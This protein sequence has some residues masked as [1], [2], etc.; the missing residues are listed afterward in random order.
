MKNVITIITCFLIPCVAVSGCT[1]LESNNG[2]FNFDPV[3]QRA[4]PYISKIVTNDITLRTYANSIIRESS[5]DDKESKINAIYRHIVENYNYL[6]DPEGV[7]L[8][9]TPQ[10]TMQVKG[11]DCEDLTILLNS[12]LEN[13]GIKT[14]LVLTDTHAYSLAYD[15]NTNNLWTY[16]EQ[17]LVKQVEN[18]WGENIRQTFNQTFVLERY[19]NWYYGGDGSPVTSPIQYLNISYDIESSKPL[20]LYIVPSR[21]DFD[22][23]SKNRPFN[24]YPSCEE[25]NVLR[26]EGICPYL[27]KNGGIILSNKN[28]GDATIKV[29]IEFYHHPSFYELFKNQTITSY[30]I[31]S[32]NCVVL[33]PTAG[34]YGY[35]G[36][37]AGLT[38]K[39]IAID[40]ISKEYVY[41]K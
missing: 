40:P 5:S 4:D 10:E 23:M 22:L 15:V 36:Y 7:E 6:S 35:P 21:E 32:T 37:D 41:L 11:G 24:N 34:E 26:I 17:S 2:L 20:H 9:Q 19:N 38:G 25:K 30:E 28:I 29:N 1:I 14:Y 39:K 18:D 13:I 16:V 27:D 12:L 8:I 31:D 3:I 33:D